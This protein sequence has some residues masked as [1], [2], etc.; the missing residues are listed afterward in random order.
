MTKLQYNLQK[1][2]NFCKLNNDIMHIII[3]YTH[4]YQSS[5]LLEDIISYV[6]TL[7]IIRNYYNRWF[8]YP[9][10]KHQH[11]FW[12]NNHIW[13][14]LKQ[15]LTKEDHISLLFKCKRL[16]IYQ[17]HSRLYKFLN[18]INND[19]NAYLYKRLKKMNNYKTN[20]LI[21]N[22]C[23]IWGLLKPKERQHFID[24]I[25]ENYN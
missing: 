12:L 19:I 1:I 21:L 22:N 23:M 17:I 18:A 11:N 13:W 9:D 24:T 4:S 7:N 10:F 8:S 20:E 5:E 16:K 6:H 2:Q 25:C 14:Y 15:G 3:P